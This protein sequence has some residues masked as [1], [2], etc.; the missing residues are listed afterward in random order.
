MRICFVCLGNICRSPTAEG[1]FRHLVARAQLDDRIH[2]DSAGT[3][4]YHGGERPDQR[5]ASTARQRGFELGG[6]ARQFVV[7]DFVRFDYVVAMDRSNRSDLLALA[8][9]AAARAKVVLLRDFV[10]GGPRDADVPDPYY[11]GGDGFDRVLD[12]CEEACAAL[13]ARV[14]TQLAGGPGR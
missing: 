6:R 1:V 14:Q 9:D 5:S 10:E 7:G 2:I 13:L 3:A 11:G 12:I 8:P 4:A